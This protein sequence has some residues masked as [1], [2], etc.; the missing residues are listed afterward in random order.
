MMVVLIPLYGAERW[1]KGGVVMESIHKP[2][3]MT[4]TT[5]KGRR[6]RRSL[7]IS[8]GRKLFLLLSR[9]ICVH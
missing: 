2:S 9:E 5:V 4:D 6:E 1:K 7:A 8:L 3:K